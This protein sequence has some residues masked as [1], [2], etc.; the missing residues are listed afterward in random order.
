MT[1]KPRAR[2]ERDNQVAG[3]HFVKQARLSVVCLFNLGK[4]IDNVVRLSEIVQNVVILGEYA[5]LPKFVFERAALLK[6]AENFID[7][8]GAPPFKWCIFYAKVV[9]LLSV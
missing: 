3:F 5:K 6:Q 1:F 2:K 4:Q 8:Q 7:L 9:Y